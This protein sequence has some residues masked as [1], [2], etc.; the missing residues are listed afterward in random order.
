MAIKIVVSDLVKFGV[1]GFIR[2]ES[3][4][5]EPVGFNLVC[6]RLDAEEI[7]ARLRAAEDLPLTDFFADIV[8]DW[9]GVRGADDKPLPYNL[10]NLRALF[11]LPGL[12]ALTFRTYLIEV[13]AKEKN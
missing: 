8:E 12:A 13:G 7:Q 2:N 5:D 4:V 10:E 11:R 1:K 9:T 6:K 3:G